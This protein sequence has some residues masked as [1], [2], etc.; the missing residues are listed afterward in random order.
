MS[1][2]VHMIGILILKREITPMRFSLDIK[3]TIWDKRYISELQ[4]NNDNIFSESV[5]MK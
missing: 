3:R 5:A 1:L 2:M 4:T